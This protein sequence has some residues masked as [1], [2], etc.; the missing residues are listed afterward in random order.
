V[1][2]LPS[3]LDDLR[4]LGRSTGRVLLRAAIQTLSVDPWLESR[5]MKTLRPNPI[6]R[7]ELRLHGKYRVLFTPDPA[8]RTVTIVVAGE[9]RGNA[10]VVRGRRFEAHHEGDP[11]Q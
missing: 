4:W 11:P 8:S 2:I 1:R 9:K 5:R 7:R 6:A 10:L 3:A